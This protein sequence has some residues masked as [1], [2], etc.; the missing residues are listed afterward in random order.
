MKCANMCF[1]KDNTAVEQ[2]NSV[3]TFFYF[4][5]RRFVYI[6]VRHCKNSARVRLDLSSTFSNTKQKTKRDELVVYKNSRSVDVRISLGIGRKRPL[7][8][9]VICDSC[10]TPNTSR[11]IRLVISRALFVQ[12]MFMSYSNLF[13][14]KTPLTGINSV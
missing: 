4:S 10:S 8:A 14:M 1:Y 13:P 2:R 11:I 6:S 12:R 7:P 5:A 9:G 3:S